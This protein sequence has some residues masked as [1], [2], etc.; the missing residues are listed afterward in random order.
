[1]NE[2]FIIRTKIDIN[3][4]LRFGKTYHQSLANWYPL[5]CTLGAH[6]IKEDMVFDLV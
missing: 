4:I 5:P 2:C 1:M 3:V 6:K